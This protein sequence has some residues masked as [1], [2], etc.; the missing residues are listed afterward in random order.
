PVIQGGEF[1]ADR[2]L[3]F[4][5]EEN[6]HRAGLSRHIRKGRLAMGKDGRMALNFENLEDRLLL[7]NVSVAYNPVT[8]SVAIESDDPTASDD[9]VI[10]TDANGNLVITGQ[11]GTTINGQA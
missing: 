8:D 5:P 11:N 2:A 3:R 4:A 6:P 9:I 7:A 10:S 1:A